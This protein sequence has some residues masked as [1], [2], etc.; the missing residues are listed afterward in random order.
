MQHG[1]RLG[2]ADRVVPAVCGRQGVTL[3]Q[4]AAALVVATKGH[5][6]VPGFLPGPTTL[7]LLQ[8]S[9]SPVVVHSETNEK[10]APS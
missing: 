10:L 1:H 3:G 4:S 7:Y 6:G 2:R 9:K 8:H 5:R